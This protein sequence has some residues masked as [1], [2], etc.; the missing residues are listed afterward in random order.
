MTFNI[1]SKVALT[2]FRVDHSVETYGCKLEF[3]HPAFSLAYSA[4]SRPC[5]EV[6][7]FSRRADVLVHEAFSDQILAE[8][9][10]S[11]GHSTAADA[12]RVAH[13]ADAKSLFLVHIADIF[14]GKGD[15]LMAEAKRFFNGKV[16]IPEDLDRIRSN[17]DR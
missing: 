16:V 11:L 13:S 17:A 2:S 12:G 10:H 9:T 14:A 5:D 7:E 15:E 4:D 1:S 8:K 6:I 3:K